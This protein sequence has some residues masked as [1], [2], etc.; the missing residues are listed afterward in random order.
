MKNLP[1]VRSISPTGSPSASNREVEGDSVRARVVR[2][3]FAAAGVK[4]D[5]GVG[6]DPA[7][8]EQHVR[9]GQ[10]RVPAEIDLDLGREPAQVEPA[11]GAVAHER[12]LRVPHLG[13]DL[14]HPCVLAVTEND[15]GL[16]APK[17]FGGEGV[18]DK[19][20]QAHVPILPAPASPT[21][22][23]PHNSCARKPSYGRKTRATVVRVFGVIR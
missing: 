1:S 6:R 5:D 3:E 17:G 23:F 10:G 19:D 11:V 15:R 18:H 22:D 2:K 12:G 8:L 7:R 13:C 21:P 14:A 20:R 16:I 4:R 9:A